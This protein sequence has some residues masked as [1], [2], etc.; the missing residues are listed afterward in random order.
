MSVAH[1]KGE[2][3]G[4]IKCEVI[5][6]ASHE[7]VA[8]YKYIY[9]GRKRVKSNDKKGILLRDTININNHALEL[10]LLQDLGFGLA[11]RLFLA[12]QTWQRVNEN[13]IVLANA[14]IDSSVVFDNGK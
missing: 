8:A 14:S 4:Y 7:E 5:V 2:H 6:D 12:K 3:N 10:V 13:K 9:M 1:V 11:P